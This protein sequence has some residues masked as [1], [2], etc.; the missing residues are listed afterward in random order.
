MSASSVQSARLTALVDLISSSVREVIE[1]YSDARQ[2]APS[3]DSLDDGP[4][5]TPATTPFNVTR[6]RQIIEAACAQLCAT[7]AQPGDCIVN[8]CSLPSRLTAFGLLTG[9][10]AESLWGALECHLTTSF[11]A[12]PTSCRI[13]NPL[14]YKSSQTPRYPTCSLTNR[15]AFLWRNWRNF[16]GLTQGSLGKCSDSLQRSIC[17]VKVCSL[18]PQGVIL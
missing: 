2:D 16:P 11:H 12:Q 15:R 18:L 13:S 7:I 10:P 6:A 8:V 17:T 1:A 3:L 5:E 9:E 4:L 14:V